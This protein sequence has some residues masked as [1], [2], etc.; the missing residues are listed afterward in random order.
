MICSGLSQSMRSMAGE[1]Q[2]RLVSAPERLMCTAEPGIWNSHGAS[3][4]RRS[5]AWPISKWVRSQKSARARWFG[6]DAYRPAGQTVPMCRSQD[7]VDINTKPGTKTGEKISLGKLNIRR[8]MQNGGAG[9]SLQRADQSM[10]RSGGIH[11]G[12]ARPEGVGA[13]PHK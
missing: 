3:R 10:E 7:H 8:G 1:R 4:R 5:E 6:R 12:H 2:C 11:C 13:G 9:S